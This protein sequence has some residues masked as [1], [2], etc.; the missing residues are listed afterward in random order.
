MPCIHPPRREPR[1]IAF[2][3]RGRRLAWAVVDPWEIRGA[4]VIRT[5]ARSRLASVRRLVRREKPS[6]VVTSS[7]P[8]HSALARGALRFGPVVLSPRS[9]N[10]PRDIASDLYPEFDLC[11]PSALLRQ[12]ASLAITTCIYAP[13]PSRRYVHRRRRAL[14]THR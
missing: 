12:A 14:R 7:V 13:I 11:T 2:V 10:I 1:I 3:P 4:G 8:F 5:G 6:A 9:P